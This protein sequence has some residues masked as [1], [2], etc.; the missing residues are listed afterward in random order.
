[1]YMDRY[2]YNALNQLGNRVRALLNRHRDILLIAFGIF[3]VAV[4][5]TITDIQ[6]WRWLTTLI[7]KV[8]VSLKILVILLVLAF[9]AFT[10][11]VIRMAL[12]RLREVDEATEKRRQQENEERDRKLIEAFK[13]ALKESVTEIK[14]KSK[15]I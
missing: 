9:A 8:S 2:V 4:I 15:K 12:R 6:L 11:Y 5:T 3:L 14:R 13:T 1:M 10:Y 7:L